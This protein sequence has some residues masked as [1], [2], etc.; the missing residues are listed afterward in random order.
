MN[1]SN[2]FTTRVAS[3]AAGNFS[4][5]GARWHY[6]LLIVVPIALLAVQLALRLDPSQTPSRILLTAAFAILSVSSAFCMESYLARVLIIVGAVAAYLAPIMAF[7]EVSYFSPVQAGFLLTTYTAIYATALA[8]LRQRSRF[9]NFLV[10]EQAV[11][12]IA[13]QIQLVLHSWG[14]HP[15]PGD[16]PPQVGLHLLFWAPL[17]L[18]TFLGIRCAFGPDPLITLFLWLPVAQSGLGMSWVGSWFEIPYMPLIGVII[19]IVFLPVGIYL[20]LKPINLKG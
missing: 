2:W 16:W 7:L 13:I 19:E 12:L 11:A 1:G 4:I 9:R 20:I 5:T 10:L 3:T 17:V 6:A 15:I 14:V 8:L 18:V